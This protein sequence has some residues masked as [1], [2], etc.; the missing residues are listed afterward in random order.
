MTT[1]QSA[2]AEFILA[3]Q[4]D[5]LSKKTID[6]YTSLLGAFE[7]A[8]PTQSLSDITTHELRLYLFKL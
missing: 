4:A 1:I 6:W 3:C 5:G 7:R 2:L 8:Y